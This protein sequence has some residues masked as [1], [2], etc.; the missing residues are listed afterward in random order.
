[1]TVYAFSKPKKA[2]DVHNNSKTT[3]RTSAKSQQQPQKPQ[4][5]PKQQPKLFSNVPSSEQKLVNLPSVEVK[6]EREDVGEIINRI[7]PQ[8]VEQKKRTK[9]EEIESIK[10]ELNILKSNPDSSKFLGQRR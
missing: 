9:E 5:Q 6:K 7:L 4:Q 3:L 2:K 8:N 1:P 10:D